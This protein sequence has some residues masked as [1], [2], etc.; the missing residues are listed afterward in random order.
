[1]AF[2]VHISVIFLL[3]RNSFG[4]YQAVS[5]THALQMSFLL[6]AATALW[7]WTW[8]R[9]P[10]PWRQPARTPTRLSASG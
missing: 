4:W 2:I 9:L 7:I 10:L 3:W 6:V 1:M 8:K 5:Y